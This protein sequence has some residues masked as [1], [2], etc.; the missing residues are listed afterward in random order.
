MREGELI[1]FKEMDSVREEVKL[2][3][4]AEGEVLEGDIRVLNRLG[5]K[6]LVDN[7][8]AAQYPEIKSEP[9]NLEQLFM[10]LHQ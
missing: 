2:L 7:S 8:C 10:A 1:L 4:L 3:T 9:M 5:N 6:V